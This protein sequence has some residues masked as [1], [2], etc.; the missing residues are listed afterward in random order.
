IPVGKTLKLYYT[1]EVTDENGATD[2]KVVE[3]DITGTN[4]A[5]TVWVHTTDDGHDGNWTTGANWGTGKAPTAVDDV[6][7]VTDQLHPHTPA[8]PATITTGTNAAAHSVLMNDFVVDKTQP[9]P[10]TIP[11]ELKLETGSSLTIGT[12][13]VMSADSILTNAGTVNIG[14]QLELKDDAT[15]PVTPVNESVVNNSG[16]INIGQ[17]GDIQGVASVT[18]S[19]TIDLKGGT[20]NLEVGIANSNGGQ[21]GDVIVESGAKLVLGADSNPGAGTHGGVTG[22]TVTVNGGGE[23]DLTGGNTLGSGT[24]AN[25][26]QINVSGTGNELLDETVTN[27]GKIDITGALLVDPSSIDDTGGGSIT[28]ESSGILE[29]ASATITGGTLTNA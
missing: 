27:T 2:T 16:T 19:G 26:G 1:I 9:V 17:G 13:L 15:N 4:A 22:G 29:L 5:A 11:P 10:Q 23:L 8:Y 7:I 14:T 12:S 24:L 21:G 25:G 6:I 20:L 18:N 28:V 3:V